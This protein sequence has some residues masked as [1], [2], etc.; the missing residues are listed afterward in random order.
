MRHGGEGEPAK[1]GIQ[2]WCDLDT[3]LQYRLD[4]EMAVLTVSACTVD[5]ETGS[6]HIIADCMEKVAPSDKD[7]VLE[8]LTRESWLALHVPAQSEVLPT[9]APLTPSS[10]RTCRRLASYPS[11]P[12][13]A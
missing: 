1:V 9:P 13:Q 3:V 12:R 5:E 11:S 6:R 7:A 8:Q 2:G 4:W 10:G